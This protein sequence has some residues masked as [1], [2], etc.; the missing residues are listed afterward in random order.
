MHGI[1]DRFG[2][3]SNATIHN[4]EIGKISEIKG[5]PNGG[6]GIYWRSDRVNNV[7]KDNTVYGNTGYG[8][9]CYYC[10]ETTII[11]NDI[12]WNGKTGL[13]V[14]NGRQIQIGGSEE[15]EGNS[16]NGNKGAGIHL[17]GDGT[18]GVT[19]SG[20]SIGGCYWEE[21]NHLH[22]ITIST[23]AHDNTIGVGN[24]INW[25]GR[26]G[27]SI[28]GAL[29]NVVKGNMIGASKHLEWEAPN[30]WHGVWISQCTQNHVTDNKIFASKIDGVRIEHGHNNLIFRNHIGTDGTEHHWGNGENGVAIVDGTLNWL[31]RNEVAYNGSAGVLI[32]GQKSTQNKLSQNSIYNNSG[33]GVELQGGANNQ[34]S[35]PNLSSA[36]ATEVKGFACSGCRVEIFSDSEDEGRRHEGFISSDPTNGS[37]TFNGTISGPNVTAIATGTNDFDSSE[38]SAPRALP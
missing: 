37:F 27:I 20:N 11:S 9:S 16:I 25:N 38:F 14:N 5:K 29:R 13:Y 36:S 30:G 6:D 35:A 31:W 28:V 8:I 2:N 4:N 23:G 10:K 24:C 33:K 26:T 34:I 19:I 17:T 18:S 32:D 3:M 1:W 12:S 15:N 22:G 7:I 21:G